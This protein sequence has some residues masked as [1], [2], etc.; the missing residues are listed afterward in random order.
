MGWLIA[1]GTLALIAIIPVGVSILFDED[2]F[3]VQVIAG[4]IRLPLFPS[5]GKEKKTIKKEKKKT[6][7]PAGVKT[8]NKKKKGGSIHAFLPLLDRV[9]DFL[10]AFRKKLRVKNL[11]MKLIL[12]DSDPDSLAMNYGKS[13]AALGNLMPLLE[14]VFVIQKR[15]VEVECDF[16][17]ESTTLILQIDIS[18]TIGRIVALLVMQGI[19]LVRELIKVLNIRKGGAKA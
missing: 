8:K 12:A 19:P 11:Q 9:L 4:L 18:I 1:L 15:N 5:K 16:L 3:R 17:A 13:W 2:G 7:K 10:S 6:A 14:A